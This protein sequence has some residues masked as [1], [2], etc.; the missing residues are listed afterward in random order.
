MIIDK[1]DANWKPDFPF[2]DHFGVFY[3][4][5]SWKSAW[6]H[7]GSTVS[8]LC[9][10]LSVWCILVPRRV[11]FPLPFLNFLCL[12]FPDFYE[13]ENGASHTHF[14]LTLFFHVPALKSLR[15]A[16]QIAQGLPDLCSRIDLSP[17]DL[18]SRTALSPPDLCSRIVLNSPDL[19]SRIAFGPPD[20]CP[21]IA[22]SPPDLCS[23]IVL[24]SPDLCSWIALTPMDLHFGIAQGPLHLHSRIVLST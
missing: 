19:C 15:S 4:V 18:C 13:P 9:S 12:Y 17:P 7:P 11:L 5:V 24:N 6:I 20:P 10:S 21:R 2:A 23:W 16:F 8:H 14:S 1:F 3:L 22:L